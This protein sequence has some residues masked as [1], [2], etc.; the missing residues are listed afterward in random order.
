MI[1]ATKETLT[2][3]KE[4]ER[5]IVRAGPSLQWREPARRS[6][7]WF[8][9]NLWFFKVFPQSLSRTFYI[10]LCKARRSFRRRCHTPRTRVKRLKRA[11]GE[12][13]SSCGCRHWESDNTTLWK[14]TG[15]L[16]LYVICKEKWRKQLW[17]PETCDET[18]CD[19]TN[20]NDKPFS[21]HVCGLIILLRL[22]ELGELEEWRSE[23]RW[24]VLTDKEP[25][26]SCVWFWRDVWTRE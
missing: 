2:R 15:D 9:H 6:A 23:S 5:W 14:N 8:D 25:S 13:T 1:Q 11:G 22:F 3:Q 24:L 17:R 19:I 10:H 26:G 12:E 21:L 7:V 20:V 16:N 18:D 4:K